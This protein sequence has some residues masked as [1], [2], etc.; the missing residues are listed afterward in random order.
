MI[1]RVLIRVKVIQTLYSYLLTRPDRTFDQAIND[2]QHSFDKS[3]ELYLHMLKLV[4]ELTDL[5]ERRLDEAKHRFLPTEEDLNP[6]MRFVENA[7]AESIRKD[8]ELNNIFKDRL[9][10]WSDEPIFLRLM[11]DKILNSEPYHEYMALERT[12]YAT[13]CHLWRQLYKQVILEDED[14]ND[15]VEG[16]SLYVSS[17]DVDIMGQFALKTIRR[18][19]ERLPNPVSPMFKDDEDSD[20]GVTLFT[21]TIQQLDDNNVLI[22]SCIRSEKW[23]RSRVALMDR[24]ILSTAITEMKTFEKIPVNVTFN[25]YIDL[26][27][28]FSTPNS[29]VFVNGVLNAVADT[30]KQRGR[31]NK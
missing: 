2:L 20:F 6:N 11:L 12:D 3:Y 22:D 13:D 8:E 28:I 24:I 17:E 9:I 16:T 5:Q 19:E 10:S 23:D 18:Y 15:F 29:G 4:V 31:I 30:L 14:F 7:L 1:N 26:A 27:K 25:E 21:K